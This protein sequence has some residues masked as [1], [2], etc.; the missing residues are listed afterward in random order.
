MK[1]FILE[2][3]DYDDFYVIGVFDSVEK[4]ESARVDFLSEKKKYSEENTLITEHEVK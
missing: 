1:V 2:F 3:Q 4:A